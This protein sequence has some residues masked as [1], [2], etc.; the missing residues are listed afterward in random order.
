MQ[1]KAIDHA[2]D[3]GGEWHDPREDECPDCGRDIPSGWCR[4][5]WDS[6]TGQVIVGGYEDDPE[7]AS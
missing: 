7:S 4:C 2:T 1:G 5:R 6:L 3:A